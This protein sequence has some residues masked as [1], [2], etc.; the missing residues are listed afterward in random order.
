MNK[1]VV[2]SS[3]GNQHLSFPSTGSTMEE[4]LENNMKKSTLGRKLASFLGHFGMNSL[5]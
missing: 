4:I 1:L 3:F 2:Q 5:V